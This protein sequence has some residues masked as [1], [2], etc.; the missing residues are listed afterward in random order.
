MSNA[1]E[2]N[3]FEYNF[4]ILVRIPDSFQNV[5][6]KFDPNADVDMDRARQEHKNLVET[7]KKCEVRTIELDGTEEYPECPFIDD[8]VVAIGNTALITRPGSK[9]RQGEVCII[10]VGV[11]WGCIQASLI[12]LKL[13]CSQILR[14]YNF[15]ISEPYY[16]VA[17]K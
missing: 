8:C 6:K 9:T 5:A 10:V 13:W 16:R 11:S 17:Y 1:Y 7:L 14:E 2:C 15:C 4:A 12:H 3:A